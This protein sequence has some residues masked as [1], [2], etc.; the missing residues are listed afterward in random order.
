MRP[1]TGVRL[2][3]DIHH[4]PVV[5]SK[6]YRL[7]QSDSTLFLLVNNT[8]PQRLGFFLVLRVMTEYIP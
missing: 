1:H 8:D 7:S 2:F 6:L 5:I 3:I 4:G